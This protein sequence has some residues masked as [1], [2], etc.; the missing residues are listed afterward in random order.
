MKGKRGLFLTFLALVVILGLAGLAQSQDR[1][2]KSPGE[3]IHYTGIGVNGYHIFRHGGPMWVRMHG[4]GGVF[5]NP[6]L[7][8]SEILYVWPLLLQVV[9]RFLTI[10]ATYPLL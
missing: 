2:F 5:S 6:S 3:R 9:E 10:Q 1:R 4:G 8:W 7:H